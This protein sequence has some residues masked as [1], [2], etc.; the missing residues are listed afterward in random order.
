MSDVYIAGQGLA[1]AEHSIDF[2]RP[3]RLVQGNPKRETASL[4]AHPNMD[5][6]IWQC[7]I[8][9]W[10]IVFAPNK[11]EF[12]TILEGLVRIHDQQ[13]GY[14]EVSA[15]KAGIIPPS[16]QGKFE[17]VEAVKKYYVVVEV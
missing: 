12:F 6:G 4:Y 14:I 11:Q 9:A 1:Q 15:G 7:E 5:C 2:P 10:N 17:V 16:F 3:D 8:G 13:G